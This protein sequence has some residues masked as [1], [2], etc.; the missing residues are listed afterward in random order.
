MVLLHLLALW[1]VEWSH[2][3]SK[4]ST[5]LILLLVLHRDFGVIVLL[6]FGGNLF[7]VGLDSVVEVVG[8]VLVA[9]LNVDVLVQLFVVHSLEG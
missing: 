4:N 1:H 3:L 9:S 2:A 7:L 6:D 8:A 5:D